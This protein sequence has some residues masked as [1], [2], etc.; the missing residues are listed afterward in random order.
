M[1]ADEQIKKLAWNESEMPDDMDFAE[2][3]YFISL[4]GLCHEYH[5]GRVT[6]ETLK[7]ESQL[8]HREY[9]INIT[10]RN[11]LNQQNFRWSK[12]EAASSKFLKEKTIES[13]EEFHR[14]IYNLKK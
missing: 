13:A 14:E 7:R 6:L 5:K 12:I 3:I 2:Q 1:Y 4:R 11:I 10:K 8:I 9:S